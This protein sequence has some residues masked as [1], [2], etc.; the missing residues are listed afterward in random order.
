MTKSKYTQLYI[1]FLSLECF[2]MLVFIHSNK[3]TLIS[4]GIPKQQNNFS[5]AQSFHHLVLTSRVV[6]GGAC[7]IVTDTRSSHWGGEPATMDKV[8]RR[9]FISPDCQR[10]SFSHQSK[11]NE[12]ERN[13]TATTRQ[14]NNVP[15]QQ[16]AYKQDWF[17]FV[18][19]YYLT[20]LVYE[21]C[22]YIHVTINAIL[23]QLLIQ[24][25]SFILKTF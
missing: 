7:S 11:C 5:C 1:K 2:G 6:G 23:S 20:V 8:V 9:P 21:V 15:S 24:K 13:L 16:T 3:E 4:A 14:G 25:N 10:G 19:Y 12:S 18:S 22:R 17:L